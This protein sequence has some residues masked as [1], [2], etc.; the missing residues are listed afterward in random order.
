MKHLIRSIKYFFYFAFL[1]TLIICALVLTGLADGDIDTMFRGGS[2]AIWKMA[3]FFVAIAAVYPKVGFITRRIC[4]DRSWSE[5]RNEVIG[6]MKERRYD[7]ESEE[8]GTVT[9][10]QRGTA[11]RLRRMYEDRVTITVKDD[12]LEMEGLRKDV[13]RL[14]ANLE[15]H[16]NPQQ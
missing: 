16:L 9:F 14:S 5:T 15:Y 8:D 3:V 2:S 13:F 4:T 10:R 1:T 6:F 11:D 7:L 12:G